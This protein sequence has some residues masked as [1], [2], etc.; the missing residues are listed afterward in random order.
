MRVSN[1]FALLLAPLALVLALFARPALADTYANCPTEPASN[2]P[3][4][5]GETFSGSNCNLH[6][7][8][9]VDSFVFHGTTGETYQLAAAING[10]APTNICLTL[11]D[12]SAMK[13]ISPCSNVSFGVFSVVADQKLAVTGTYTIVITETSNAAINYGV[14]LERLY[15]FPSDAQAVNKIPFSTTGNITPLTDSDAFTFLT[16]TTGTN[17]VTATLTSFNSNLCMT[18]YF[19]NFTV[20]GS[21][22]TNISFGG[23]IVQ[24]DLKPTSAEA[25]T[26][27]AFLQ[28]DGND[29]TAKYDL[30]VSCLVGTCPPPPPPP[31]CTLNDALSYNPTTSTLTMKFTVANNLKTAANW[32]AWL[33]YDDPQGT[34]LDTMQ[35]L[36]SVSQPTTKSPVTITKTFAGLPKEGNVGVLS[37]LSTP[38]PSPGSAT[39]GIA[40]SSWVQVNTGTDPLSP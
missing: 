40:C 29:S 20:A 30:E 28:V 21:G 17:R 9:D 24:I 35:S 22:C 6:T 18:V 1:N 33:T 11:Y 5:S 37:T 31:P 4:A 15:P 39:G 27:M 3:I 34:N 16:A 12:P 8:G 14:S 19:S 10:A 32:S 25:G 38:K 26:A 23:D 7:D 36:F 13:I 2:V